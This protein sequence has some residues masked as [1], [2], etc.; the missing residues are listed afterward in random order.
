MAHH[1]LEKGR[2]LVMLLA[3]FIQFGAII[4]ES[5]AICA[6]ASFCFWYFFGWPAQKI[7][8]K[9]ALCDWFQNFID[10]IERCTH[11]HRKISFIKWGLIMN[12]LSIYD[13]SPISF[14]Q[15]DKMGGMD[16]SSILN[17]L[18]TF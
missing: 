10:R 13:Y 11:C 5:V 8:M 2:S 4:T 3:V 6:S 1:I 17:I 12:N 7:I 18:S 14:F 16:T 9:D 15:N